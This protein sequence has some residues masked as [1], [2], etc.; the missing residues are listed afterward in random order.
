ML[1]DIQSKHKF[2]KYKLGLV[3]KAILELEN[4]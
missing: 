1:C 4:K 2:N 3:C